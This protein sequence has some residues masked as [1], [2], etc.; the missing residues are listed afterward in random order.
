MRRT[1]VLLLLTPLLLGACDVLGI[2]RACTLEA[3]PA[4]A[5]RIVDASTDLPPAADTGRVIVRDGA[6]ADSVD[7]SRSLFEQEVLLGFAHERRGT[8]AVSVD[9]A[10]YEPWTLS[11][12]RVGDTDD[13]CHVDTE[14]VN[15]ELNRVTAAVGERSRPAPSRFRAIRPIRVRAIRA[16]TDLRPY[17][18]DQR[19]TGRL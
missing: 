14:L 1:S 10:G 15:A 9:V 6:Y 19:A 13:G 3:R 7:V 8:Y 17:D 18:E 11:D 2:D 12:V 4:I 5:V 16:R